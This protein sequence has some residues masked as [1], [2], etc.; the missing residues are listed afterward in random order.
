MH[1]IVSPPTPIFYNGR[2]LIGVISGVEVVASAL[3]LKRKTGKE[4][5][6]WFLNSFDD[7]L[8]WEDDIHLERKM[9]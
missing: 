6:F 4:K 3:T 8:I 1:T 5:M 7:R 2:D 9:T